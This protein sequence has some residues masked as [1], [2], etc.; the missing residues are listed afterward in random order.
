MKKADFKL[1]LAAG[2]FCAVLLA[3]RCF[4]QK[5]GASVVVQADGELYG[6]YSL[7]TDQTIYINDTNV[8]VI[9]DGE[10]YMLEADCPDGLC[11]QQGSI[12][13]SGTMIVCLPNR[14][15]VQ[16]TEDGVSDNGTDGGYD[17]VTG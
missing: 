9:E 5:E 8:L 10:A 12:S 11:I 7:N 2:V 17:A 16:V 14:V 6:T 3:G 4:F 1:L 15:V 13:V